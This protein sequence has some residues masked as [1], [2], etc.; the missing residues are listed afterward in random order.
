MKQWLAAGVIS[1]LFACNAPKHPGPVL[2]SFRYSQAEIRR[3][4]DTLYNYRQTA[5]GFYQG[6]L[7]QA[8]APCHE[9]GKES[10]PVTQDV[11]SSMYLN[12]LTNQYD[13]LTHT[14]FRLPDGNIMATGIFEMTPGA[15]VAPDH[16]FPIT[17]GSGAY[18][19]IQGTYT[20]K[21][22]DGIYHIQLRYYR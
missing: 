8:L 17:G 16:D 1:F 2:R 12:E 11:F 10:L 22:K 5:S 7:E 19:G 13:C 15:S 21:Y 14:V 6:F 18:A 4:F 3:N 20:R 9:P